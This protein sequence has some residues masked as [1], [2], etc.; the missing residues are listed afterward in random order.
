MDDLKI[1]AFDLSKLMKSCVRLGYAA[2]RSTKGNRRLDNSLEKVDTI[3][4]GLKKT[5]KI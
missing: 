3:I 1:T 2:G 5:N 4:E